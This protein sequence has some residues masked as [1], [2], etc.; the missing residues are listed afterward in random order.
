MENKCSFCGDT[1]MVEQSVTT[2]RFFGLIKSKKITYLCE[3]HY[4]E[5]FKK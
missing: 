5:R 1:S 3:D 2:E 4:Y